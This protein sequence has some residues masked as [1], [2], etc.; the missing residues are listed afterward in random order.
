M[1][2]EELE[3]RAK[4][5]KPTDLAPFSVAELNDYIARLEAEIARA[6]QA[7]AAKSNHRAS[8]DAFFKKTP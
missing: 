3:P 4:P 1:D 5:A 6:R 7:I 2:L 8:A